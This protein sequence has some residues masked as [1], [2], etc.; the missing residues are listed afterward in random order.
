[1]GKS[2]DTIEIQVDGRALS[3][4]KGQML[5]E[6]TDAHGIYV[7][8]FC[9]HHKLSVAANCRMCLVEVEKVPKPL[10]AC[11]T[12][13]N[14]G[15]VVHTRSERAVAAQKGV[16]E[17]LLIN[18]PLDCPICDQGG[19]CEL[20]DLA[21]AYGDDVSRYQ[22][23]KRVVQDKN[24]GA[25]IQTD[26]TRCIHC[27]RCVRFG[28]EIAGLRELGATGRGE[29]MEIGTYV[30]KAVR[31]EMSGNVIDLCPVGALTSKPFRY[32]ARAWE[33]VQKDGVAPHDGVGSN[34]HVHCKGDRVKRVVPRENESLNEVWL[35]DRDRYS[36]QAL[37]SEQRLLVPQVKENGT[38]RELDWQDALRVA[39]DRLRA[40]LADG[41]EQMGALGAANLSTEELY[42]LQ[43]LA[44]ALGCANVDHRV[45]QRDFSQQDAAPRYPSLGMELAELENM[46]SVLLL[47]CFPRNE[48]PMLN[49]RLRKAVVSHGCEVRSL[50]MLDYEFNYDLAQKWVCHPQELR[51]ELLAILKA[52]GD[53]GEGEWADWLAEAEPDDTH[54]RAFESLREAEHACVWL[55]NTAI[56][57]PWFSGLYAL[58]MRLA[59]LTGVRVACAGEAANSAG[60]CLAGMLPHRLAG[61]QPA[62]QAGL[63]IWEQFAGSGRS[64]PCRSWLLMGLEPELD[65][66]DGARARQALRQA[67]HVVVLNAF[68]SDA[69][70]EYADVLLPIAPFTENTGSFVN[71]V[72]QP[73]RFE[74]A[75]RPQG[76][77]RLGWKLLRV[78]GNELDLPGFDWSDIEELRAEWPESM[79][80]G[81]TEEEWSAAYE[82]REPEPEEED[83]SEEA[84]AAPQAGNGAL[85]LQRIGEVPMNAVDGLARRAEALR[86][87]GGVGDGGAHVHPDTARR[88]DLGER[89]RVCQGEQEALSLPVVLDERVPPDCV[90]I[91]AAQD[92]HAGLGG[93][94]CAVRLFAE[95]S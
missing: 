14:D 2:A 62:P 7:P 8:R 3:A 43:K 74:A 21:M 9:Y 57:H 22:E 58:A 42:A 41:A 52:G 44:R 61:G 26:M 51:A 30:A 87:S 69:M 18:H 77:A 76:E 78:L 55:G 40:G 71:C 38:W 63:N 53:A 10:P 45:R 67:D 95:G 70:R 79:R 5:I 56:A 29:H 36:Y 4:V 31:S 91:H 80:P 72:G 27:T 73:Q 59:R 15:M 94:F 82:I 88:G 65:C 48:H 12:P 1:M 47:G 25:L 11:A 64:R 37:Y 20:Q 81:R 28:E 60:A 90:M 84:A 39:R 46:R 34:L 54:R 24:I 23:K 16:M 66:W 83:S 75:T 13:V 68:V 17:F 85:V 35:S 49:H 50:N 92:P 86:E 93:S 6:V 89:V 32:T 33:L 19:E